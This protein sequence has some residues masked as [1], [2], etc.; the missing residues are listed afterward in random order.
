M[1]SDSGG[2]GRNNGNWAKVPRQN[3]DNGAFIRR[4]RMFDGHPISKTLSVRAAARRVFPFRFGGQTVT[5]GVPVNAR[6]RQIDVSL[7]VKGLFG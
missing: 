3:Q 4:L 2:G 1:G 5:V 6:G 7:G